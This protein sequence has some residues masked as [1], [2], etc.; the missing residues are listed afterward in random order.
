MWYHKGMDDDTKIVNQNVNPVIQGNQAQVQTQVQP[1]VPAGSVNK[2]TSP[3][4]ASDSEFI[5]PSEAEPRI[6]QELKES[7]I[8]VK[9]DKP[10][11]T[12]EHQE[13]GVDHAGPYV[14]VSSSPKNKITMS[15][16]E[17]EIEDRLKTGQDDDSGKWLAG[18]LQKIMKVLGL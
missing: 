1:A 15:M 6:N 18:L 14:P 11:L 17:E 3:V 4:G 8:E 2:E 12:F 5:K 16:S 10:N 13:L 7:G 9:S